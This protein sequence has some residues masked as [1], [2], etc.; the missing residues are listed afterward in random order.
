MSGLNLIVSGR[1]PAAPG[2]LVAAPGMIKNFKALAY[3][4]GHVVIDVG[5]LDG[6]RS[7][8]ASRSLPRTRS[9]LVETL[10][11][12]GTDKARDRLEDAGFDDVTIL[13][14]GRPDAA[15][16]G[17]TASATTQHPPRRNPIIPPPR[18]ETERRGTMR[19]MVEGACSKEAR[20]NHRSPNKSQSAVRVKVAGIPASRVNTRGEAQWVLQTI[21]LSIHRSSGRNGISSWTRKDSRLVRN[22]PA[23]AKAFRSFLC[24]RLDDAVRASVNWRW[25][26][27]LPVTPS[28]TPSVLRWT[29]GEAY[30]PAS[31]A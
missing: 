15:A 1:A 31:G 2:E 3:T 16:P 18:S 7:A 30:R 8:R 29:N 10:S 5:T 25:R 12:L 28:S 13:V 27:G 20:L 11:N 26:K 22:Y 17:V 21:R 19:S 6:A 23:A 4:Y 24:R 9:L 14:A